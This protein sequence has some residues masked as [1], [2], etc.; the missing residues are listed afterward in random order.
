MGCLNFLNEVSLTWFQ[1]KEVCQEKYSGFL[2]EAL[3][4]EE[5]EYLFQVAEM[6]QLYTTNEAWWIGL[7]DSEDEDIWKWSYSGNI[8]TYFSWADGEPNNCGG[9]N[10]TIEENFVEM[11]GDRA[12]DW[13]DSHDGENFRKAII[14]QFSI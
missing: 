4:K 1:A 6:I 3:S 12:Y 5:G 7:T 2:V 8:A 9:K 11:G 14:C 10:C 13:N